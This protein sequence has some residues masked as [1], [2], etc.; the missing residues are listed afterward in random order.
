MRLVGVIR[1][2]LVGLV[3][4]SVSS[5]VGLGCVGPGVFSLAYLVGGAGLGCCAEVWLGCVDVFRAE[6]G[7]AEYN[8]AELGWVCW[9]G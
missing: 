9:L 6:L 4:L 5:C 7:W 1:F 8:C 3:W 2:G